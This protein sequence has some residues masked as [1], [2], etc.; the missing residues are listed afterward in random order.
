MIVDMHRFALT[1]L[2]Y[3]RN[4]FLG[5]V[6]I[7]QKNLFQGEPILGGS[8]LHVTDNRMC[9]WGGG[10]GGGGEGGRECSKL[11]CYARVS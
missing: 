6:K 4:K 8:K 11:F 1:W 7:F 5:W 9:V 2:V 3:S 10:R